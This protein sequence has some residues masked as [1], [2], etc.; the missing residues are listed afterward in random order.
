MTRHVHAA[1]KKVQ[2]TFITY[3]NLPH[4]ERPGEAWVIRTMED[5]MRE[6]GIDVS[7]T[8]TQLMLV[9]WS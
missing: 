5:G 3:L 7:E 4:K 1:Q 8:A 9:Y 6:R 2:E